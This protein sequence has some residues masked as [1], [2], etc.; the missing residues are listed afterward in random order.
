M[1]SHKHMKLPKLLQP[2]LLTCTAAAFA[3]AA[4]ASADTMSVPSPEKPA[5][6]FDVP[7]NWHPKFDAN[8]ES[9]EATAPDK[10]VYLS[11]WVAKAADKQSLTKDISAT[12][13]DSMKSVEPGT[14]QEKFEMNGV[15]FTVVK[16]SGIDK[17]E[18]GKV[19]FQVAVFSTGGDNVGVFYSDYDANAPADTMDVLQGIMKSIKIK[20]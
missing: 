10:H 5:Y 18:G 4:R 3:L 9:V 16:G 19:R 8:D 2:L 17:R 11:A 6:T 12:L 14:K 20:K 13:K 1:P 15:E 7:S